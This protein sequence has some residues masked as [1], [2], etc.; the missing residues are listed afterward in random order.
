M[1][2]GK[3]FTKQTLLFLA[4]TMKTS[5]LILAAG[6][7]PFFAKAIVREIMK[8]TGKLAEKR[9]RKLQELKRKKLIS[10]H[11]L[12]DGSLRVEINRDGKKLIRKYEFENLELIRPPQW[13]KK[14]RII[15][16][17]LPKKYQ[18]ASKALSA[19]LHEFGVYQLQKS[20][21]VSPFECRNELELICAVFEIPFGHFHYFCTKEIPNERQLKNFFELA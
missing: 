20:V 1:T 12:P 14:W 17:D 9:A 13:D 21:W 5:L 4:R 11:E 3:N 8:E 10:I 15:L 19:K 18:A 16:Y 7:S 6:S 2:K